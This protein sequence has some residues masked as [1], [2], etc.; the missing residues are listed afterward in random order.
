[1]PAKVCAEVASTGEE[2]E[3]V[4]LQSHLS[5]ASIPEEEIS[6]W[7]DKMEE[8]NSKRQ[9][10]NEAVHSISGGRY[11][12]IMSTL[13]TTWHDVSDTAALLYP[14]SYRDCSACIVSNHSQPRGIGLGGVT[15]GG[16]FGYK[17][18]QPRKAQAAQS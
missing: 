6:I 3:I 2:S 7:V 17:Q 14:Q 8:Q 18:R 12:P 4:S 11:S 10:L 5:Q 15:F 16:T 13:N 9:K 1:M